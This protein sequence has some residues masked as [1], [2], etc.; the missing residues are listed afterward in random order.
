[1]VAKTSNMKKLLVTFALFMFAGYGLCTT[2]QS[3]QRIEMTLYW[4]NKGRDFHI[5]S[6]T[7]PKSPIVYYEGH[8]LYCTECIGWQITLKQ[9]GHQD[10][11]WSCVIN[12]DC[13]ELPEELSGNYEIELSNG[14]LTYVGIIILL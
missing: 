12:E 14:Y 6:R 11:N 2:L 4:G 3:V 1:M 13:I 7:P 8:H 9:S 5:P 10:S